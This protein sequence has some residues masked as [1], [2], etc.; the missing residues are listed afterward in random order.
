MAADDE[1]R[2]FYS[3]I[4]KGYD[5]CVVNEIGYT[6]YKTLPERALEL[7]PQ[8][9]TVLDLACGTGLSSDTFFERGLEVTGIDY[10]P[11]M[12]EVARKRPYKELYC[13]R[14]D[15]VLPVADDSFDITTA[16]GVTEFIENPGALLQTVWQKLSAS[17]LFALTLPI[18]SENCRALNI[19]HYTLESFMELVNPKEFN[20]ADC[21]EMYGWKSGYLAAVDGEPSGVYL[22]VNYTAVFLRKQQ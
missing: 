13:Q 19:K 12:I 10:S 16:I 22:I 4:A 9:K 1:R 14:I 6:A 20:L 17:G 8:A 15:D 5:D 2:D 3:R 21:F 11:G 7:H 18:P